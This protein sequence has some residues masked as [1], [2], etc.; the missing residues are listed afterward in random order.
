MTSFTYLQALVVVIAQRRFKSIEVF[1]ESLED[2]ATKSYTLY[3]LA[4]DPTMTTSRA[5]EELYG[6]VSVLQHY[7]VSSP[8][9]R[10][11]ARARRPSSMQLS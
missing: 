11:L 6:R 2:K 9:I 10:S 8:T 1:N 5:I 4:M 7:D 3:K